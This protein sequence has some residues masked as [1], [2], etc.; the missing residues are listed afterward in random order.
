MQVPTNERIKTKPYYV[1][2]F[3]WLYSNLTNKTF[4]DQNIEK[5]TSNEILK[6]I[7]IFQIC[8]LLKLIK[9]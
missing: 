5:Y 2:V 9:Y 4:N 1:H 6:L 3:D 7:M 8:V